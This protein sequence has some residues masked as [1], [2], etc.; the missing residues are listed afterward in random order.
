MEE[1]IDKDKISENLSNENENSIISKNINE[2]ETVQES[3]ASNKV[4]EVKSDEKITIEEPEPSNKEKTAKSDEM[5]LKIDAIEDPVKD[6]NATEPITDDKFQEIT[7]LVDSNKD[8]VQKDK[9]PAQI[10]EQKVDKI[11]PEKTVDEPDNLT[12]AQTSEEPVIHEEFKVIEEDPQNK[13]ETLEIPEENMTKLTIT[14]DIKECLENTK[15]EET[16]NLTKESQPDESEAPSTSEEKLPPTRKLSDTPEDIINLLKSLS[17][18]KLQEIKSKVLEITTDKKDTSPLIKPKIE[19]IEPDTSE[20]V[21][22][23][24]EEQKGEIEQAKANIE[25]PKST[26]AD[27]ICLD[28]DDEESENSREPLPEINIQSETAKEEEENIK[29]ATIEPA[30]S[31]NLIQELNDEEMQVNGD[32]ISRLNLKEC[33]NPECPRNKDDEYLESPSFVLS[34]YYIVKKPTKIQWVCST[35]YNEALE[36]YEELCSKF[37]SNDPWVKVKIPKKQDLVEIIDSDEEDETS[38]AERKLRNEKALIVFDA[39]VEQEVEDILTDLTTKIDIKMQIEEEYKL[40]E[41]K[42]NRNEKSLQEMNEEIKM[43]ERKS[44]VLYDELYSFNRPKIQRRPSLNLEIE[45]PDSSNSNNRPTSLLDRSKPEVSITPV[46]RSNNN[47]GALPPKAIMTPSAIENDK[48]CYAIRQRGVQMPHWMPC[49]IIEEMSNQDG[50]K[51]K[52]KFCDNLP[53][54]L[55]IISGKEV[56]L[57]AIS[58][59]LEIGARV[60]ALFPRSVARNKHQA[61]LPQKRY[62]PGVIGEKLTQYNKRRYLVFCDYGQVKYCSPNEV[63]EIQE[64]SENVWDDV[65][66]NLRQ[67]IRDYLESKTN[68]SRALLN[69]RVNTQIL[70]ERA[71]NWRKTIVQEVDCSLVKVYFTAEHV[72]EWLYRGSKRLYTMYQQT[73]RTQSNAFQRRNDPGAFSYITIDDDEGTLDSSSN[74]AKKNIAKKSTAKPQPQMIIQQPAILQQ[75]AMTQAPIILNDR[76]IY[77]EDPSVV[78]KVRHFTPK[79]GICAK[80]YVKHECSKNCLPALKND[81]SSFSPLSKPLLSCWERQIVRQRNYRFVVYKAPCGRRLRDMNEVFRFLNTSKCMLNVDNFDFDPSIQVLASYHVDK[82]TC[83]LFIDDITD[84]KEGMKV[85]CINA[86]DNQS[87]PPLIYS[88]SRIPMNGVNINTDPEFMSCCDCTD[89]CVDK[90]KCACFQLTIRGAKYK[91]LMEEDEENISYLWKRLLSVVPTGIYE[92]N[93]RCKCSDRCLNKVV[94]QPVR[95]KMQLYRTKARGWGLQCLHDIPKGTFLSIYAGN[96]YTEKDANALCQGLDHGDEYFAELDLIENAENRKEGYESG[97][98]YPDESDEEKDSDSDYDDKNDS[99]DYEDGDFIS[100]TKASGQ[101]EIVTRSS[102][103]NLADKNKNP[104][105]S[106]ATV[107][108]TNSG[109]SS[110]DE[111][112]SMIPV[113]TNTGNLGYPEGMR[114]PFRKLYGPKEKVYIMDAKQCGNIGRYFNHSCEPNLFVQSVFVDTHDLRF[115]WIAFFAQRPIKAG[116]ELTWNYNYEVG[117]VPSKVLYCKCGS[118]NCRGRIL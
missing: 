50:K 118:K 112:V 6:E 26:N 95:I 46:I 53:N 34:M 104:G 17:P 16:P 107:Q 89:E 25:E 22:T 29:S 55:T 117:S 21:P 38:E 43:L 87:P 32:S 48:I 96:L 103:T 113:D 9:E 11:Q 45:L 52:V 90:S 105:T 1:N 19:E 10:E 73:Q 12:S 30:E 40:I 71:G 27:V 54:S 37:L 92:C 110:D 86:F 91:N 68:R 76:N 44:Y 80:K 3:T 31:D 94:Q 98:V 18:E 83:P 57:S 2:P 84:G 63:R 33:I 85:N 58:D 74:E 35:C 101:R 56:S 4:D 82:N 78:A 88:A 66:P 108:R 8:L 64:V 67:F 109:D 13:I 20:L 62:L 97:I 102:R 77:L 42:I 23:I 72:S 65:H 79:S 100:K 114:I 39:E 5:E 59:K 81:L 49:Q 15:D 115:P 36:T 60:I 47:T 28:S 116:E 7:D 70:T 69:V 61:P 106:T 93:S 14:S 111:M 51:F 41:S 99:H 24:E 75:P